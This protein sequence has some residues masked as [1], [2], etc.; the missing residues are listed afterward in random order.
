MGFA[1]PTA[2]REATGR[3]VRPVGTVSTKTI[4]DFAAPRHEMRTSAKERVPAGV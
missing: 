4:T 1:T 3:N 2:K